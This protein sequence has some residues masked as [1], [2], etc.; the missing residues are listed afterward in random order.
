MVEIASVPLCSTAHPCRSLRLPLP[1]A[2]KHQ[3]WSISCPKAGQASPQPP[4]GAQLKILLPISPPLP[5]QGE[6][7][8]DLRVHIH[9]SQRGSLPLMACHFPLG[10]LLGGNLGLGL[11]AWRETAQHPLLFFPS[12]D[13]Q[14][15][16]GSPRVV[17]G[18]TICCFSVKNYSS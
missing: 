13:M 6:F 5:G 7:M 12:L 2:V 14:G 9:T 8:E 16:P 10:F 11:G 15:A 4:G 18:K 1:G 17:L 3:R